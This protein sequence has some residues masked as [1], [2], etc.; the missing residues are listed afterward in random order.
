MSVII[1]LIIVIVAS[2][3]CHFLIKS[4]VVASFISA[5][6]AVIVFQVFNYFNIGYLD[7]F[8]IIAMITTGFIGFFVSFLIGLAFSYKRRKF[9]T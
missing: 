4:N 6:I 2:L 8:F 1:F 7:P 9:K 5:S 3:I